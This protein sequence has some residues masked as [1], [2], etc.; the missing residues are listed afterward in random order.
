MLPEGEP[1][2]QHS[3]RLSRMSTLRSDLSQAAEAA[4]AAGLAVA[5]A[6]NAAGA[7]GS[8]RGSFDGMH[9]AAAAEANRLAGE[10]EDALAECER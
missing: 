5:G 2:G 6:A 9:G 10:L 3:P 1:A 8:V 7:A 4:L